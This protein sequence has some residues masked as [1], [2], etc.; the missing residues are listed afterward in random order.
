[1][2]CGTLVC[3]RPAETVSLQR[4]QICY[5]WGTPAYWSLVPRSSMCYLF[6]PVSQMKMTFQEIRIIATGPCIANQLRDVNT[7]CRKSWY[8]AAHIWKIYDFKILSII[9]DVQNFFHWY[10]PQSWKLKR[11]Q[12]QLHPHHF[13]TYTSNLMTVVNS[14]LKFMI[15]GTTS[16]LKS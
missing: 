15:N 8:I 7:I 2:C 12:I 6:D 16:I 9:L 4:R 14:V 1:M 10:L 3:W 11:P 5:R 13:W